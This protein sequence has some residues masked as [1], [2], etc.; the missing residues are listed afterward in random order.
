MRRSIILLAVMAI[1]LVLGIAGVAETQECPEGR[2]LVQDPETGDSTC[3]TEGQLPLQQTEQERAAMNRL[4]AEN[5]CPEGQVPVDDPA[6]GQEICLTGQLPKTD[7]QTGQLTCPEGQV[8]VSVGESERKNA[9]VTAPE[10][11]RL[12][13]PLYED[14]EE[15]ASS[16]IPWPLA[17]VAGAMLMGVGLLIRNRRATMSASNLI[18]LGGLTTMVGGALFLANPLLGYGLAGFMHPFFYG[19]EVALMLFVSVALLLVPVGM[20]GFHHL[21]RHRYGRVGLV[22]F[23]LS[24]VASLTVAFGVADYFVWGDFLQEEPPVWL[25]WGLIGLVVGFALYGVATLQARVLPRWCGV[26]FIVALPVALALSGPL[27]FSSMFG[28]FGLA[29]LALGYTLWM[30]RGAPAEQQHSRVR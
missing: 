1:A 14:T 7:P 24:V 22:G 20:V 27:P 15:T 21:Q 13:E 6:V 17:L 3:V 28:V 30:R 8:L 25:G 12:E 10:Q 9:C 23:W 18:R 5:L 4:D 2:V 11:R 19:V 29:W 26:A 16:G